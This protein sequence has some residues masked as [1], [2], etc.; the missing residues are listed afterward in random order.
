MFMGLPHALLILHGA[1][2]RVA[3]LF[4]NYEVCHTELVIANGKPTAERPKSL[5]ILVTVHFGDVEEL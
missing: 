1:V 4:G 2:V 5:D 3:R